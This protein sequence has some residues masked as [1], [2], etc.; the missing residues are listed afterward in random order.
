MW[1]GYVGRNGFILGGRTEPNHVR[2]HGMQPEHFAKALQEAAQR[3][4]ARQAEAAIELQIKVL[5][6]TFDR[7]SAY[8][9]VIIL[10]AYAGFFGLWQLTKDSISQPLAMWAALLMLIS[11]VSFVFFEVVK[12]AL[13]QHNFLG[14]AKA[15]KSPEV[16]ASPQALQKAFAELEAVH[17]RVHFH[18]MRF[19]IIVLV[20]TVSTG[21]AAATLLGYAFVRSLFH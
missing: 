16:R 9:N 2:R 1:M 6:A 12:M 8:T 19:W 11:V 20:I 10:A 3:E 4:Q 7:S 21:M 13:I 18:F 15:L 5:S 17:E 14:A